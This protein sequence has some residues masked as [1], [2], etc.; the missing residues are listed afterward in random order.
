MSSPS[1]RRSASPIIYVPATPR[2]QGQTFADAAADGAATTLHCPARSYAQIAAAHP[3]ISIPTIRQRNTQAANITPVVP[4]VQM[5]ATAAVAQLLPAPGGNANAA[6]AILPFGGGTV[7]MPRTPVLR[8]T[9]TGLKGI[10]GS[11]RLPPP[12]LAA[13]AAQGTVRAQVML[14]CTMLI[15]CTMLSRTHRASRLSAPR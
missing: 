1:L 11:F 13:N 10:S 12:A 7:F 15:Y 9:T 8:P 5:I 6:Q 2:T 14:L 3:T 4:P